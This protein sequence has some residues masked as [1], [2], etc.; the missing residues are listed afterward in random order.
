MV[1]VTILF[2]VFKGA[3][4][5][6][7]RLARKRA[8]HVTKCS[9]H[10]KYL[11]LKLKTR[12]PKRLSSVRL[13]R[14]NYYY[15]LYPLTRPTNTMRSHRF[16]SGQQDVQNPLPIILS[17]TPLHTQHQIIPG[18]SCCS[19]LAGGGRGTG[20]LV[21]GQEIKGTGIQF[22]QRVVFTL[23]K[24]P[25]MGTA[26]TQEEVPHCTVQ[27]GCTDLLTTQFVTSYKHLHNQ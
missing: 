4:N 25:F 2:A 19:C 7:L 24:F 6:F 14:Y 10:V 23:C 3:E 12:H 20:S 5:G 8:S 9:P 17:P 16:R 18:V 27:P 22:L 11:L 26:T 13:Q 21:L 15:T 1:N